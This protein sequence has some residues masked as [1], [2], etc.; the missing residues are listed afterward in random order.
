M[1]SKLMRSKLS[2]IIGWVLLVLIIIVTVACLVISK[3]TNNI[4]KKGYA[5]GPQQIFNV[6]HPL[7]T[8]IY[9]NNE[10]GETGSLK[11]LIDEINKA[12]HS[13]EIAMFSFSSQD[14][15]TALYAADKR[16]VKV[17][18]VFNKS[19]YDQHDIFFSDLPTSIKRIDVGAY[20]ANHSRKTAYMHDKMMFIDRGYPNQ[21]FTTGSLNYTSWG[22]KYNQ[23]FFL[24]TKDPDIISV[25]GKEFDLLQ[26]KIA[27]VK[28]LAKA[29]YN[30]WAA[31]INYTDSFLQ[32]WFS[33]GFSKQ[34]I[35]YEVLDTIASSTKSLDLIMWDLTDQ[36]IAQ[37]LIK[38]AHEGV[39][40]R[41]IAEQKTSSLESSVIPLIQEAKDKDKLD[42][43]E[44]ILDTKLM[45]DVK[46]DVPDDFSPLIH[47]HSMIA[48]GKTLIFGSGNWS[49]WG[50][51]NNDENALVTNN[52]YLIDE[53]QKTFDHFYAKLK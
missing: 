52:K 7:E 45:E 8:E 49:L 35:K 33:P 41:L 17:T 1:K 2:K 42:N 34:S 14:I 20:D 48:D 31:T 22:E 15:K 3:S 21:V 9:F 13:I 18:L 27:G 30:P 29:E 39:K 16:G 10:V 53:S 25:Y 24:I 51:Y 38:K 37:A 6:D 26:N 36:Q 12:Q 5:F 23:S 4:T 46:E 44:I 19:K 47:H 28:K 32:I 50:F 43:L 40:I 11:I